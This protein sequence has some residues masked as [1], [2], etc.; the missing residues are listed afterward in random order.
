MKILSQVDNVNEYGL[1]RFIDLS[2]SFI[3]LVLAFPI[4]LIISLFIFIEDRG[5]VFYS[6]KRVG[7]LGRLFNAFK[8]RTMIVDSDARFGPLQATENDPRITKVGKLLRFTALD[9]IP[10]LWSILK[11]DMSFVGPRALLPAEIETANNK[12]EEV[13]S[14]EKIAG[15]EKRILVKPGLTGIAQIF[16]PRDIDRKNKFRYDGLYLNNMSLFFDL[17]LIILSFY[18]TFKGSWEKREKKI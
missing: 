3:G 6:Q 5:P 11:G 9:E 7:K 12:S 18:I 1:K 14:L 16:A 15:Y 13:V 8:F 2:L 4:G 10:Q 17:K